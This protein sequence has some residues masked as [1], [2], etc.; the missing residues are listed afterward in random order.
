MYIGT[1]AVVYDAK[2]FKMYIEDAVERIIR[3]G[4]DYMDEKELK[5]L[6]CEIF[7]EILDDAELLIIRFGLNQ[8]VIIK[9]CRDFIDAVL[10]IFDVGSLV[11]LTSKMERRVR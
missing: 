8:F 2:Y 4:L 10:S 11:T 6:M 1:K 5:R 7:E 3:L 9:D